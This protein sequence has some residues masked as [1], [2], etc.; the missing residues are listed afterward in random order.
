[1]KK[2]WQTHKTDRQTDGRRDRRS[3]VFLGGGGCGLF[4]G[5]GGG[6]VFASP[7]IGCSTAR[8]HIT[9]SS[10]QATKRERAV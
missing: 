8:T 5:G 2:V 1:M 4:G 9:S 6:S 10:G 3:E 7:K